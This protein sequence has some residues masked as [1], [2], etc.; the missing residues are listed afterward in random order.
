MGL[1]AVEEAG[2]PSGGSDVFTIEYTVTSPAA[3][4]VEARADQVPGEIEDMVETEASADD[5][6]MDADHDD[7]VPLRFCS[8]DD[9]YGPAS[10]QGIAPQGTLRRSSRV[11]VPRVLATE[12]L[13]AVSCDE[14]SS[15][16]EAERS[17]SWRNAMME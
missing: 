11:P 14:P 6:D 7:G 1:G 5:D 4:V 3:L 15:F 13:H 9:L 12:E 8:L 17:P 16:T 10:S 2:E